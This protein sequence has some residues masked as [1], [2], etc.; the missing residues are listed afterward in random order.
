MRQHETI[1]AEIGVCEDLKGV[2]ASETQSSA[3]KSFIFKYILGEVSFDWFSVIFLSGVASGAKQ[4]QLTRL[5]TYSPQHYLTKR[6]KSSKTVCV[7]VWERS[8][9]FVSKCSQTVRVWNGITSLSAQAA[10][11]FLSQFMNKYTCAEICVRE[12]RECVACA[13]NE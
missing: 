1:F 2:D 6:A 12:S 7:C 11:S 3:I 5:P 13:Y 10:F 4:Q 9:V 8:G